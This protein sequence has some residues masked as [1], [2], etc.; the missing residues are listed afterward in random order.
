MTTSSTIDLTKLP[1]PP[2]RRRW[3]IA[4]KML[5]LVMLIGGG[6]VAWRLWNDVQPHLKATAYFA[7]LGGDVH[8]YWDAHDGRPGGY[9]SARFSNTWGI[10]RIDDT[11]L[12]HIKDLRRLL[13]LDLGNCYDITDK[14]LK[15]LDDLR[16]LEELS[17]G[18]H[19]YGGPDPRVS[20][21]GLVHIKPL[22]RLVKLN[23]R[24]TGITDDGLA[25]LS[26]LSRLEEL[27]LIQTDITDKGLRRLM[28]L[29][30]LRILKLEGTKVTPKGVAAL[31][32][33]NPALTI[34]QGT[35]SPW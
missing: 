8:W 12:R 28:G 1:P 10:G 24:G 19:A 23:L 32:Q 7:T 18:R 27:N 20:D 22:T 15:S 21:A 17:L 4:L 2:S 31:Q 9:S 13:V 6:L 33:A 3:P 35:P 26:G 16:E 29:T 30:G 34:S 11:D 25:N 5:P 14:G